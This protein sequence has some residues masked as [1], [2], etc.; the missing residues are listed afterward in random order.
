MLQFVGKSASRITVLITSTNQNLYNFA[1]FVGMFY[2]R[3]T[4]NVRVDV[5]MLFVSIVLMILPSNQ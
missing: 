4:L 3:V 1:I 5:I 2:S